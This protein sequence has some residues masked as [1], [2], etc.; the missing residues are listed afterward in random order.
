MEDARLHGGWLQAWGEPG[1]GSQFRMTLPR[2]AGDSL[3]GS[4]IPMEPD[5]SRRNR[6]LNTSGLPAGAVGQVP[7]PRTATGG[8]TAG[9]AAAAAGAAGRPARPADARDAAAAEGAV[10]P[11]DG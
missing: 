2:T 3:R 8:A 5:D 9:T 6:G 1:G 10:L 11:A 7:V 4:P